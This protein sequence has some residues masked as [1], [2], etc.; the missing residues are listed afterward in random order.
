MVKGRVT[1]VDATD[2]MP[3]DVPLGRG[4]HDQHFEFLGRYQLNTHPSISISFAPSLNN[5]DGLTRYGP[6][7]IM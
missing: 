6:L 7:I 4:L 5:P 2:V 1:T 3:V